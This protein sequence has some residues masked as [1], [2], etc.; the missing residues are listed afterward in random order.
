[1]VRVKEIRVALG[2]S[3]AQLSERIAEQGVEITDAGISN[4]ENGNKKASDRLLIAWA[5]ALGIEPLNV[6][7]GPLRPAI[8]PAKP[9]QRQKSA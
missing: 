5:K 9:P 8:T 7:H 2:L 4:V 6:W 3:Q 1:M